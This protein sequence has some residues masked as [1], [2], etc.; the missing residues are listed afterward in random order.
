MMMMMMMMVVVVVVVVGL[1]LDEVEVKMKM[2]MK[3]KAMMKHVRYLRF[4]SNHFDFDQWNQKQF[5]LTLTLS[6]T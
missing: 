2:K 1:L 5:V 6:W 4:S 3:M